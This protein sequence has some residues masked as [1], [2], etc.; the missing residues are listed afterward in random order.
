MTKRV[1]ANASAALM[2]EGVAGFRARA[3]YAGG[4]DT[5]NQ[6]GFI[7]AVAASSSPCLAPPHDR[8]E[9][10]KPLTQSRH[11]ANS[12]PACRRG[13]ATPAEPWKRSG[14]SA[15]VKG[16]RSDRCSSDLRPSS[17]YILTNSPDRRTM[18][19]QAKL[20]NKPALANTTS[21]HVRAQSG[22]VFAATKIVAHATR[23]MLL[24]VRR[25]ERRVHR[26]RSLPLQEAH[27]G[28]R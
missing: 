27:F 12:C 14:S 24:A 18:P 26:I 6:K 11:P 15:D 20:R 23:R 25:L 16:P 17:A 1:T 3:T 13:V 10:E 4:C 7:V 19:I 28:L 9:R 2:E 8:C 22:G 5:T 21:T